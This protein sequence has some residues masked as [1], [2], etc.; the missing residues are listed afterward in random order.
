M[1]TSF[2]EQKFIYEQFE[3]NLRIELQTEFNENTESE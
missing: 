1:E 3:K 2:D